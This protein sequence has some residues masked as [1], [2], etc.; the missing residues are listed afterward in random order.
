MF[1]TYG[2][3]YKAVRL[4]LTPRMNDCQVDPVVET[5]CD[6][7]LHPEEK[8]TRLW[9]DLQ[10]VHPVLS[11]LNFLKLCNVREQNQLI[12]HLFRFI[13]IGKRHHAWLVG[14]PRDSDPTTGAIWSNHAAIEVHPA[15]LELAK[16]R[17]ST[18]SS[19][20]AT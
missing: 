3:N 4:N 17:W 9:L 7:Y 6:T 2:C 16:R 20:H 15:S 14:V 18:H 5:I 11:L 19:A 10:E 13:Q 12:L 8:S 1:E